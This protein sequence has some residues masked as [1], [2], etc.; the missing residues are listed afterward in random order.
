MISLKRAFQIFLILVLAGAGW[1]GWAWLHPTPEKAI[2]KEMEQLAEALATKPNEGN[3]ARVAAITRALSHFSADVVINTEGIPGGGDTVSGKTELQQA[4][5]AAR[6]RLSGSITF[7]D[8]RV[9]VESNDATNATVNFV[10]A[11]RLSGQEDAFNQSLRARFAKIE[12]DWL[13]NHVEA[14]GL[15]PPGP[16]EK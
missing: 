7:H 12:G 13:I 15:K 11:A 8:I 3:I 14:I 2:L 9:Q 6:S 1:L 5:F 16:E 4:L 10:A